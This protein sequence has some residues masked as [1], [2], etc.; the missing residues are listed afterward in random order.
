MFKLPHELQSVIDNNCQMLKV[1]KREYRLGI[2]IISVPIPAL[3]FQLMSQPSIRLRFEHLNFNIAQDE[4]PRRNRF[5][6]PHVW[7]PT[8]FAEPFS[9]RFREQLAEQSV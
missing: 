7:S 1:I 6:M 4:S 5:N 9:E 3:Y 8:R 2:P